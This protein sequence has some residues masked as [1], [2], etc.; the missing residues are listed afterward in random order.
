MS[1]QEAAEAVQ[2]AVGA[3]TEKVAQVTTGEGAPKLLKD[4]VTGEMVSKTELKKR[5][6]QREKDAKKAEREAARPPPP[7]TSHNAGAADEE[8][9]N[10]NVSEGMCQFPRNNALTR[11]F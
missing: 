11:S 3:V 4:E 6:K 2:D 9:L 8:K 5:L 7:Q 1:A 10:P